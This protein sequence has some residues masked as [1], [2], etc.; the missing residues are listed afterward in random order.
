MFTVKILD[1]EG[2]EAPYK[3][4]YSWSLGELIDSLMTTF[5]GNVTVEITKEE[6]N[7]VR[8]P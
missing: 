7:E 5:G 3:A 2:Y 4:E 1:K 8:R 6:K